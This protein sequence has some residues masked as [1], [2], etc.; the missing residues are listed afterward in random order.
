MVSY[1]AEHDTPLRRRTGVSEHAVLFL[2]IAE[3]G[4][5]VGDGEGHAELIFVAAA[6]VEAMNLHAEAAAIGVVSDL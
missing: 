5:D 3:G 4:G 2:E 1:L 6:D